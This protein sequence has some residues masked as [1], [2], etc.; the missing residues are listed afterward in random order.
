MTITFKKILDIPPITAL[1]RKINS[2]ISSPS[3]KVS[4]E[5]LKQEF[6][7]SVDESYKI[8]EVLRHSAYLLE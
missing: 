1:S 2:Y 3:D 6:G 4:L 5:S 7:L 8:A